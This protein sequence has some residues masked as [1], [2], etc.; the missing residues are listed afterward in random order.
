MSTGS[1]RLSIIRAVVMCMLR[2]G[3]WSLGD[4]LF[5][6]L[7]KWGLEILW[8]EFVEED[9]WWEV[10]VVVLGAFDEFPCEFEPDEVL[11]AVGDF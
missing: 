3:I 10:S 4:W 6:R 7:W 11:V 9:L 5:G 8:V 2:M 1:G